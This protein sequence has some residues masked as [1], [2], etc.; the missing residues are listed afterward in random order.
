MKDKKTFIMVWATIFGLTTF[1]I[2][3]LG[4]EYT[5]IYWSWI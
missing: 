3:A 4:K 5:N 2:G 1:S